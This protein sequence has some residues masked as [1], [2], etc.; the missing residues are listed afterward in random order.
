MGAWG[1]GLGAWG[2]GLGASGC[3]AGRRGVALLGWVGGA[4]ET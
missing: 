3:M 2:C 1:C 4:C